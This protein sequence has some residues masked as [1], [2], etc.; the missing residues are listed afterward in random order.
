[1]AVEVLQRRLLKG[2]VQE[3]AGSSLLLHRSGLGRKGITPFFQYSTINQSKSTH[4]FFCLLSWGLEIVYDLEEIHPLQRFCVQ[5]VPCVVGGSRAEVDMFHLH[6]PLHIFQRLFPT[7]KDFCMLPNSHQVFRC[8]SS[9]TQC[10]SV[11][12]P[13]KPPRVQR[14]TEAWIHPH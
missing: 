14:Y 6:H 7:G 10:F 8:D 9:S 5:V 12:F 1:M 4:Y 2:T 3:S 13:P 11:T